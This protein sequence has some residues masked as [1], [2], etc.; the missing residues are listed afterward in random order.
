MNDTE[1]ERKSD[2]M[3]INIVY[4]SFASIDH[5]LSM[6]NPSFNPSLSLVLE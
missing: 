3:E 6:N 1:E 4:I 5:M 2:I